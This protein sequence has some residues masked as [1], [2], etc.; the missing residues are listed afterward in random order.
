MPRMPFEAVKYHDVEGGPTGTPTMWGQV[1]GGA[2]GSGVSTLLGDA[3]NYYLANRGYTRGGVVFGEQLASQPLVSGFGGAG[4]GAGAGAGTGM[5]PLAFQPL[6]STLP[7]SAGTSLG[8]APGA[9]GAAAAGGG[10][11]GT[12]AVGFMASLPYLAPVVAAG[13]GILG[14]WIGSQAEEEPKLVEKTAYRPV[15][16]P[17][18]RRPVRQITR[19]TRRMAGSRYPSAAESYGSTAAGS[20]GSLPPGFRV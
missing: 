7:A 5:A 13:L 16:K 9:L 15:P 14:A 20:Y 2:V 19:P 1:G 18:P 3:S 8:M 10:A 17:P 12:G 6:S 4:A 11:A